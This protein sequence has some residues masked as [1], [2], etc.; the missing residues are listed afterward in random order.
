MN[1]PVSRSVV[2][3]GGMDGGCQDNTPNIQEGVT[4][5]GNL[6]ND[7]HEEEYTDQISD[8]RDQSKRKNQQR[9]KTQR[10]QDKEQKKKTT[11]LLPKRKGIREYKV[12]TLNNLNTKTRKTW[13]RSWKTRIQKKSRKLLVR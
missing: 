3:Y 2:A 4:K 1:N 11:T 7:R 8:W 12:G 13:R 9:E 10:R 6:P 5:G